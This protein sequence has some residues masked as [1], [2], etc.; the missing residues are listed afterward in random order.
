MIL[1]VEYFIWENH[2]AT[3]KRTELQVEDSQEV[4]SKIKELHKENFISIQRIGV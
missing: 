2:K 4:F 3:H 1:R